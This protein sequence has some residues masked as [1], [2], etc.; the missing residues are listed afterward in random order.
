[1]SVQAAQIL[2]LAGA[3]SLGV[4]ATA[5]MRFLFRGAH[6]VFPFAMSVVLAGGVA[7]TMGW[8]LYQDIIPKNFDKTNASIMNMIGV[9]LSVMT[10]V[11]AH[12]FLAL[13]RRFR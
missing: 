3:L 5:A 4:A 6:W 8:L 9:L 10:V 7:T 1:M 12:I 11:M 2:W 13:W